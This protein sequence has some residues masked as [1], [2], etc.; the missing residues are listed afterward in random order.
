MLAWPVSCISQL[1]SLFIGLNI[2]VPGLP[3]CFRFPKDR[4][5]L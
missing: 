5:V 1:L 4:T 3:R 2:A